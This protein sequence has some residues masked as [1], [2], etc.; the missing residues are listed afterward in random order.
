MD[1]LTLLRPLW[2]AAHL[3]RRVGLSSVVDALGRKM[4]NRLSGVTLAV[5][6]VMIY[7]ETAGHVHYMRDTIENDRDR[8]FRELLRQAIQPGDTV[9]E[10]GAHLG[11]ITIEAARSVG[12]TGSVHAFEPNPETLSVLDGNLV[13]NGVSDRI[14]VHPFAVSDVAGTFRFFLAGGGESSSLHDPGLAH[15][16]IEVEVVRA[17]DVLPGDLT[18]S[19]IKLDTE[20][21]EVAA[22]KGM[23]R[24][25]ERAQAHLRTLGRG[26]L[27]RTAG[28]M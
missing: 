11:L 8:Y 24:I 16:S 18:V 22:L 14:V 19:V 5:D 27:V 28:L 6:G 20:G 9:I 13:A 12:P 25:L 23:A 10:A 1:K 7:C 15:G 17:D 21:N 4:D 26:V 3:M 2:G